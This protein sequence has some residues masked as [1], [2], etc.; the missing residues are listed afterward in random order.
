MKLFIDVE[1]YCGVDLTKSGVYP[2]FESPDFE[3]LL[4][5]YAVDSGKVVTF[6]PSD[7]GQLNTF[8]NLCLN[9]TELIA[10]NATFE[11]LAF[12]AIGLDFPV[13]TC[14]MVK[15]S[16]C[17]LP[18][19]LAGVGE[20]L[21][22]TVKKDIGGKAL[23]RYFSLPC[24]PTKTNGGRLRNLPKDDI[25]KWSAFIDYLRGDVETTRQLYKALSIYKFSE[26]ENYLLDQKI[27]D[28][29]VALDLV[30]IDEA[31]KL[32]GLTTAKL[33]EE[34]RQLTGLANPNS[35]AQ[36]SS[37]LSGLI[38]ENITSLTKDTV[39]ELLDTATGPAKR[40]LQLRQKTSN[41]SV[42]KFTAAAS[43]ACADG[44]ARGVI[45]FYGAG[46]TGRWAG[47]G[48]QVQNMPRNYMPTLAQARQL[49][50]DG[51]SETL[52]FLYSDLQKVLKELTRT[53]LIAGRGNTFL[54]G[55]YS[56]I[57][58]RVLAWLA[59]EKWRLE[60]FRG[61]GKIYEASA[62]AMFSVPIES[63][64]KDSPY[65]Q[66]GKIA[67]LALGFQGS[68]GAL[69]AMGGEAMGLDTEEMKAIVWR[70]RKA[71]PAIVMYWAKVEKAAKTALSFPQKRIKL[72]LL[73]FLYD[74][75]VLLIYLPSGRPLVYQKPRLAPGRYGECIKH[76]GADQQ[77]KRWVLL[78]TYGGK[79]VENIVQSVARDLLAFS[80][81]T[82]DADG[83]KIVLHVHDEIVAE[84]PAKD[85]AARL[86]RLLIKMA[87]APDWAK[88]LPLSADGFKSPFYKKE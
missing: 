23:I 71:N 32:D 88:G 53:M 77:T 14:T 46:R 42:K 36:L 9:A 73:T 54:V 85:S 50:K 12:R 78:D 70:W 66:K 69:I 52:N 58:A 49:V 41:T 28:T 35:P 83:F 45:Q 10:H 51:D 17:G 18:M 25:E 86:E 57:E 21:N 63:I 20:A 29:G 62:A 44:R 47:R 60:V 34:A 38:G 67:E 19:S 30:L 3:I 6:G 43:Y 64:D 74:G 37:W 8:V 26:Q 72:G 15:A 84:A 59:G 1:T 11:R 81:A 48:I 13:W 75:N 40:A 39:N 82:V 5:G 61:H 33:I 56:A 22:L 68:V 65:R 55:D 87:E 80:L 79:L 2:Y 31:I 24:K 16:F 4:I 27:N 76:F 7:L